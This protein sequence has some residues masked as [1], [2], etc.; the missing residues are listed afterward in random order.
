ML[1]FDINLLFT[2][3]NLLI[4][5]FLLKKFLFDRVDQ[6]LEKRQELIVSKF[7][8]ANEALVKS[9]ELKIKYEQEIAAAKGKSDQIVTTANALAKSEYERILQTANQEAAQTIEEASKVIECNRRKVVQG[10]KVEVAALVMAAAA[11]VV[12]ENVTSKTNQKLYDQFI[13]EA[14][15]A[16]DVGSD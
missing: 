3:L 10:L 9:E 13:T 11:K 5:Y 6:I 1:R 16:I 4:L 12:G 7:A 2:V 14:G 15:E 8:E